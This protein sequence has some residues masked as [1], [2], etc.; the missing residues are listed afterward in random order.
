MTVVDLEQS[1]GTS[2]CRLSPPVGG[3]NDVAK[4]PPETS[5]YKFT[6]IFWFQIMRGLILLDYKGPLGKVFLCV[7]QHEH[8]CAFVV[9]SVNKGVSLSLST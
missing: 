7:F 9:S 2:C 1:F 6:G 5:D 4:L 8:V 3:A